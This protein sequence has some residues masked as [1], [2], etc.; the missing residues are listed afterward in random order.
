MEQNVCTV[1]AVCLNDL[2]IY[3]VNYNLF[4]FLTFNFLAGLEHDTEPKKDL[5]NFLPLPRC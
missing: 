4:F 2:N 3:I 5:N 1:L